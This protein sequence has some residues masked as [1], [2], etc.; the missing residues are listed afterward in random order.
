MRFQNLK[1]LNLSNCGYLSKS[2][3]FSWFPCLER[4]DLG[5]CRSLDKLDESLGQLSKLKS[6][7]L[8]SCDS[9]E[10][11]P[12]S[13]CDLKSLVELQLSNVAK[14]KELPDGVGLLKKLEV[15]DASHFY[16]LVRLPDF[17]RLKKL[18]RLS[19]DSCE[20]LEEIQGL[21]GV[22]SFEDLDAIQCCNLTNSPRKIHGQG[23]LSPDC[24][25]EL[26][27]SLNANDGICKKGLS[28]VLCIVIEF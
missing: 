11:L 15:L 21:E 17:S 13:I 1:V 8:E 12:E 28:L 22:R 18:R 7:I 6:V 26:I 10:E 25:Q 23:R 3:N 4:L 24:P 27:Y 5:Y 9:L 20:K 19:V 14:I 2:P 16:L